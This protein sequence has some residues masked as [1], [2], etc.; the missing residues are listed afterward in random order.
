MDVAVVVAV[1][2]A[3]EEVGDTHSYST[4]TDDYEGERT[5]EDPEV[6]TVAV[7]ET[8]RV[9]MRRCKGHRLRCVRRGMVRVRNS[10]DLI[11]TRL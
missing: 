1:A 7:V 6:E 8:E 3:V 2:V 9:C 4:H 5:G 10:C 11:A